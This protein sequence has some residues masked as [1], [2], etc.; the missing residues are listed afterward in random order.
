MIRVRNQT[1]Q[2][3]RVYLPPGSGTPFVE[4]PAG[5]ERCV[6]GDARAAH[7]MHA[8]YGAVLLS[9]ARMV[10]PAAKLVFFDDA[11]P[12]PPPSPEPSSEDKHEAAEA[13]SKSS[14][15]GEK[16]PNPRQ[17]PPKKD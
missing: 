14:E 5:E 4:I 11:P 17:A 12:E 8:G 13:A 1:T 15:P 7:A 6:E 2:M 3:H 9:H 16:A 10:A